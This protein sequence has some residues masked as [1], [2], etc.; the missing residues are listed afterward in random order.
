M[1]EPTPFI[2][3]MVTLLQAPMRLR[4]QTISLGA[5]DQGVVLVVLG[6]QLVQRD[7]TLL[8]HHPRLT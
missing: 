5:E 7:R 2:I 6:D 3:G 4:G 1:S 8:Q